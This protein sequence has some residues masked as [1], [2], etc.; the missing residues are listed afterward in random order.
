MIFLYC[1]GARNKRKNETFYLEF[2]K[3]DQL[4]AHHT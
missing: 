4:T 2:V 1:I 3:N